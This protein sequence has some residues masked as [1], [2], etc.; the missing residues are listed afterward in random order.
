MAVTLHLGDC[1]EILPTLD[2]GS[3]D[4]IV[5]DPP[6][7]IRHKSGSI[8][9]TPTTSVDRKSI[10]SV[11]KRFNIG[12]RGDDK[13]FDPSPW[14]PFPAV[15]FTGA[16]HFYSRL[17]DGGSMHCWDKRGEYKPLD[18]ADADMIWCSRKQ[19]SRVFHLVWRGICR[20]AEQNQNKN[21]T[22]KQP[23]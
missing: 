18:Q 21:P 4:A 3:I 2:L 12:I 16:Q 22:P 5:T 6:Y 19:A 14:I 20:H 8:R 13:P 11:G 7:G 9:R 1:L 10:S 15:A 17:P 23:A